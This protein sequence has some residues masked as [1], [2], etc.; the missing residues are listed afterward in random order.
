MITNIDLQ[1]RVHTPTL[2]DSDSYILTCKLNHN[3]ITNIDLQNFNQNATVSIILQ[4]KYICFNQ[5]NS[6]Q[7]L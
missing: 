2:I 4:F 7:S 3:M 5:G 1:M 6:K